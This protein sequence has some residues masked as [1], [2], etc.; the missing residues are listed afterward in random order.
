[1]TVFEDGVDEFVSETG[2][3]PGDKPDS[4]SG[5]FEMKGCFVE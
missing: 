2:G 5:H 3:S 1:M 4:W